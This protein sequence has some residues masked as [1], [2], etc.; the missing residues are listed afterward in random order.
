[1]KGAVFIEHLFPE[2][3][4]VESSFVMNLRAKENRHLLLPLFFYQYLSHTSF[5]LSFVKDHVSS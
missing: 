2:T 5:F 4:C 1:M 3:A